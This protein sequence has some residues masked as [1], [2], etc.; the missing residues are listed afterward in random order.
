MRGFNTV[1]EQEQVKLLIKWYCIKYPRTLSGF[2]WNPYKVVVLLF[3]S[4]MVSF[5][6]LA[7]FKVYSVENVRD[8]FLS[9]FLLIHTRMYTHPCL[10][11]VQRTVQLL[12]VT[13]AFWLFILKWRN[14]VIILFWMSF[15]L[16][17]WGFVTSSQSVDMLQQRL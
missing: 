7:H 12:M 8:Y 4:H 16:I 3:F 9:I 13:I 15:K 2:K 11:C 6:F 10:I 5:I 1:Q 17:E 14:F